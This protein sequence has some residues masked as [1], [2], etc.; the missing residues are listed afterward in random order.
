M[1]KKREQHDHQVPV[2]PGSSVMSTVAAK[3]LER[4]ERKRRQNTESARR[5]RERRRV[6]LQSLR[7]VVRANE[8][9]LNELER[10]IDGLSVELRSP[11]TSSS[12]FDKTKFPDWD[13]DPAFQQHREKMSDRGSAL[14]YP[15]ETHR[16]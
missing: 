16:N 10:I 13:I 11:A 7:K 1:T 4:K 12:H 14:Y 8:Q 6:E 5:C 3:E 15:S 2:G 9:R